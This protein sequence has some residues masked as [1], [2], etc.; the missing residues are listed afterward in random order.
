MLISF[1]D[2][3]LIHS[4]KGANSIQP[5]AAP[6]DLTNPNLE[7]QRGGLNR[8]IQAGLKPR[9]QR[10]IYFLNL[11]RA[12]PWAELKLPLWGGRIEYLSAIRLYPVLSRNGD[13]FI[14]DPASFAS[15]PE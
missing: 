3:L 11:P 6:W 10:S 15:R 4:P 2:T 8:S 7:P 1:V 12:L 9:L 13:E 14:D 5:R